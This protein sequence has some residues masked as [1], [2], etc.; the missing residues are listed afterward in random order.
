MRPEIQNLLTQIKSDRFELADMHNPEC[1]QTRG[2]K[3]M[4]CQC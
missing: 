4:I 3:N 2:L 1:K